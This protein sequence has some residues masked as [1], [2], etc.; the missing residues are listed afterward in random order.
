MAAQL[1]AGSGGSASK[2]ALS[3]HLP[4]W[5][6]DPRP[7]NTAVPGGIGA[8]FIPGWLTCPS[9]LQRAHPCAKRG[10]KIA[11]PPPRIPSLQKQTGA[12]G[13]HGIVL[14]QEQSCWVAGPGHP[15]HPR[16]GWMLA[17]ALRDLERSAASR[18]ARGSC[19][20]HNAASVQGC[21]CW[22]CLC[23]WWK[24]CLLI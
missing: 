22:F 12:G 19:S 14:G 3:R 16:G 18:L 13:L 15:E 4:P 1:P 23:G 24:T 10:A 2:L 11:S 17:K 20:K 21:L 5:H 6:P 8:L 9:I 7:Q